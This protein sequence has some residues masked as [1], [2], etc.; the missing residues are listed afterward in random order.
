VYKNDL[1]FLDGSQSGGYE[2]SHG[3]VHSMSVA[4]VA[5]G[6]SRYERVLSLGDRRFKIY[7]RIWG[8]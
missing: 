7:R 3:F 5:A 6:I 2:E 8:I 4:A 1:K